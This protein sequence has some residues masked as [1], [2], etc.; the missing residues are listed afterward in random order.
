MLHQ[1]FR[2]FVQSEQF[3]GVLLLACTI[4][5]LVLANSPFAEAWLHVWHLKLGPLSIENWINDAL[6]AVFFLMIGLELERGIYVG[7]LSKVRNALLPAFAAVGGMAAPALI[8]FA[9]NGGTATEAGFG[10]PMATDIAFALAVIAL[11]GARV[12]VALKLF[13]VAYA[14]IDDLGAIVLI[15]TVYTAELSFNWLALAL[16]TWAALIVLN[17]LRVLA[18]APYL[19]GGMLLWFCVYHAGIHASIAGVMLAFAIPFSPRM[20]A[21][22]SPSHVLERRLHKPVAYLILPLF[23]LAN[24]GVP[25]D[26]QAIVELGNANSFGIA[27]GLILGK[28]LGV[29]AMCFIAV[30]CGVSS[31]PDGVRWPHIIGAGLLGGI[32]FTMSI[33]ITNLAFAEA[34]EF[35]QSSKLA[36]LMASLVAGVLGLLWLRAAPG[37]RSRASPG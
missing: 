6:M 13:V 18:L 12:P 32:G 5:S 29:I 9:L 23:A 35:I 10:I 37:T 27:L 22:E 25:I 19:I 26:Q 8:H 2:R 30:A 24:T 15:A 14:I 7:A 31:L 4:V 11:L 20:S 28:P 34:P 36:V 16:G 1:T 17:R 33:F 21:A 3:G